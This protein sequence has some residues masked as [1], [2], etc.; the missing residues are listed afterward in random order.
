M[1]KLQTVQHRSTKIRGMSDVNTCKEKG[2]DVHLF[3]T[4]KRRLR[5][6]LVVFSDQWGVTEK[7]DRLFSEVHRGRR[8]GN[9]LRLQQ[10]KFQ[11]N[12]KKEVPMSIVR[13]CS[14]RL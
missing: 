7:R 14:K 8:E 12:I 3:N 1:D 6:D 13:H 4:E 2:R 5:G 10:G 9:A 11:L